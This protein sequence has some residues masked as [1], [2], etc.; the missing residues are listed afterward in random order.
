MAKRHL[1]TSQPWFTWS[2]GRKFSPAELRKMKSILV[3]VK[4]PGESF[5][6][7]FERVRELIEAHEA[8]KARIQIRRASWL[9]RAWDWLTCKPGQRMV[10]RIR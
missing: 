1:D 4:Q 9:R 8:N 2:D 7:R 6:Q 10:A 3:R 5:R